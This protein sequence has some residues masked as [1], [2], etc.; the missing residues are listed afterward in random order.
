LNVIDEGENEKETD[1]KEKVWRKKENK[2]G[3][4]GKSPRERK[5]KEQ[6]NDS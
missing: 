5:G 4:R 3:R 2:G 1:G 6:K